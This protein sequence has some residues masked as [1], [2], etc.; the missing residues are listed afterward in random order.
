M[1]NEEYILAFEAIL[2]G[3]IVSRILIKWNY[4]V[5]DDPPKKHYWAFW[6]FTIGIFLLIIYVFVMNK[7]SNHYQFI[8]DPKTF[9]WYGVFPPALFTFIVYQLFPK[10]F[11]DVDLKL[12]LMK[13]R[14][15]IIIPLLVFILLTLL[16]FAGSV[17]DFGSILG[18]LIAAFGIIVIILNKNWLLE[19]FA[20]L[21]LL[22]VILGGYL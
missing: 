14:A 9:L 13:Y 18:M 4:M 7:I 2:Y 19:I 17:M 10:E 1:S 21:F 15:R 22:A 5:Q 6:V 20:V 11:K 8:V 3:L 12:Y 16:Q